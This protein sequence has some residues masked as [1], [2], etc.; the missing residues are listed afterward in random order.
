[1][2]YNLFVFFFYIVEFH[3]EQ[4]QIGISNSADYGKIIIKC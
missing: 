3:K 1:M 4:E 2:T